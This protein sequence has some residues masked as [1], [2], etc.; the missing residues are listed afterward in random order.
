M[1]DEVAL[2][3]FLQLVQRR[4]AVLLLKTRVHVVRRAHVLRL[5]GHHQPDGPETPPPPKNTRLKCWGGGGGRV[6]QMRPSLTLTGAA[7]SRL[8]EETEGRVSRHHLSK[9]WYEDKHQHGEK[10]QQRCEG[11]LWED[12]KKIYIYKNLHGLYVS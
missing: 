7:D 12:Y 5:P 6:A 4:S 11:V 8:I 3:R 1:F 10:L 9:H 2:D